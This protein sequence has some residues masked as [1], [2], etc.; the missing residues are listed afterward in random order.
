MAFCSSYKSSAQKEIVLALRQ[1][2]QNTS[3]QKSRIDISNSISYEMRIYEPDSALQ[4]AT[5]NLLLAQKENYQFGAAVATLCAGMAHSVKGNFEIA[6]ESGIK[7][8]AVAE[9]LND[10][11][12]RAVAN[13]VMAVAYYN[14]SNYDISIEKSLQAINNFKKINNAEGIVKA[15]I[16]M[17]QVYQLKNDLPAAEKILKELLVEKTTDAKVQVNIMHT[18]AN[19]YGMQEKYKEAFALDETSLAISEKND[20][21]F[22]TSGIYDNMAN[23]YMYSGDAANA[24]KYFALCIA[25]D[26]SFGNSKQMADTYLN[27]GQLALMNKDYS[28]AIQQLQHSIALSKT[29]GYRQGAYTAYLTLGQAFSKNNQMDS[30]LAATN[31]GYKIKDS[32]LNKS[33]ENKIAELETLYQTEKKEQELLLQKNEIS[34]KNFLL[35]GAALALLLTVLSGWLYYRKRNLQN[36]IALQNEVLHQQDIASKAVIDAEENERKRIAADLH[37]GIGQMM[38][39]AKMNLSVFEGDLNFKSAEQKK[40]FENVIAM[41]DESCREVRNVSHQMMPNALLKS[42][43]A[44]AVKEFISRID[45]RILKVSLHTE[46]LNERLEGN[47]ETVLYRVIQEC[48]NNVLK[49]S[50]ANNLDI[51]IMKDGS[52]IS[53]SI[54]DNGRGFDIS[55][56]EKFEGIGLKNIFSRI[57]YL[58]G[59]IDFTSAPGQGTAVVIQLPLK[60]IL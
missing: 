45:T 4:I 41:V 44:S 3:T 15:R 19:V 55:R 28:T 34:K 6:L 23:C 35:A 33:T 2:L 20:F 12:L 18:L 32:V 42:G 25:I 52:G 22:L 11:S 49:H 51:S 40:Q 48:V 58:N 56:R 53:A 26:S 50:G 5:D 31:Q 10:D 8:F 14:K 47:V 7:A 16:G 24:K 21:K 38:S 46:G 57:K 30:A 29:T 1:K 27:L 54:E 39:V 60:N 37:D 36:K 17:A 13:M 59:S 43:L 9:K